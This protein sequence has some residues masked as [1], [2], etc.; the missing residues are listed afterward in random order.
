[1]DVDENLDQA[2]HVSLTPRRRVPGEI[3]VT[4]N[5]MLTWPANWQGRLILQ[6][7]PPLD[8]VPDNLSRSRVYYTLHPLPHFP[9]VHVG[10]GGPKGQK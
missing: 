9:A 4:F 3:P 5:H 10:I 2:V 8:Q 6:S 7:S 1:M